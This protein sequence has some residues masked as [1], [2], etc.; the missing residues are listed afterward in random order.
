MPS[1]VAEVLNGEKIT[2]RF[3]ELAPSWMKYP[4][5]MGFAIQHLKNNDFLMN[6]A[7]KNPNSLLQAMANVAACGLSLNPVKKEAYLVPRKGKICLDPSYM[8][9][10]KLATD[11]GS[12][13]WVQTRIVCEGEKFVLHGVDEQPTHE[14]E[15]FKKRGKPVG[16]YTVALTVD[17]SYL[18]ETMTIDEVYAIRDSSEAYKS[19]PEKTPWFTFPGEMIRKTCTKRAS[20]MWPR[21]SGYDRLAEAVQISHD[22]EEVVLVTSTPDVGQYSDIEKEYFDLL[23]GDDLAI[24]M[25]T[26]QRTTSAAVFTN[27]YHSFG[28]GTKGKY[29]RMVDELIVRGQAQFQE[30]SETVFNA[31]QSGDDLAIEEIIEEVTD[32]TWKL[33]DEA[34]KGDYI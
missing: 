22:N 2:T 5:E 18:T 11:T 28:K 26:L 19:N 21:S 25:L 1:N 33:I 6:I 17:G 23:I 31:K 13:K 3:L 10:C 27:L 29:Q 15:P 4:A 9:I 20:K 30:Y 34:T 14:V 8:G 16:V 32:E 7:S 24:E 12:I